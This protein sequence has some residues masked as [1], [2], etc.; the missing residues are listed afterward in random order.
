MTWSKER[1]FFLNKYC[2]TNYFN[3]ILQ[4]TIEV[5]FAKIETGNNG[6]LRPRPISARYDRTIF[7]ENDMR[8]SMK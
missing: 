4:H 5:S 6:M 3:D 2:R 8:Y 1:D 7:V